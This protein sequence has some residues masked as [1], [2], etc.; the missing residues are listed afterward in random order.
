MINFSADQKVL[1]L[2]VKI[3]TAVIVNV[4]NQPNHAVNDFIAS[5]INNLIPSQTDSILSG[6]QELHTKVG[7]SN[8]DYVSSPESLI[9]F[10]LRKGRLPQINPIVDLYNLVSVKSKLALGAHDISKI[11]CDVSLNLTTGLENFVP[12]GKT[13]PVVIQPN[14]YAYI[15]NGNN[16]ICRLEVIQ[17]ELTKITNESKDVFLI[18]Q[19]NEKTTQ[20]YVDK[21]ALEVCELITK[22]CGGEYK[23]LN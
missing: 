17:C 21:T 11:N 15:D 13:E 7:R 8:K 20:E 19:G 22:F 10:F 6:F 14:E 5:E 16:I 1:D 3:K 18:I 9:G 2:G 23:F 4:N 12:L